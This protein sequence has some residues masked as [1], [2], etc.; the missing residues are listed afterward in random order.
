[1]KSGG[2]L[3]IPVGNAALF[4]SLQKVTKG[5]DGKLGEESLGGVAFV[6][7]LGEYGFKF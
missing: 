1:M 7:M 6:P 2:I 5:T 3:L 4:Q